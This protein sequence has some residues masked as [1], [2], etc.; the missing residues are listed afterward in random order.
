MQPNFGSLS[1]GV[2][3]SLKQDPNLFMK[4]ITYIYLSFVVERHS[5][6]N[7][8]YEIKICSSSKERNPHLSTN[9]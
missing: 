4:K 3:A 1:F 6:N 2:L 9:L 8:S 5:K 7:L